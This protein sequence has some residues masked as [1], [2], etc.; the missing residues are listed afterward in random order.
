MPHEPPTKTHE[1]VATVPLTG[2]ITDAFQ[3]GPKSRIALLVYYRNTPEV[4]FLSQGAPVV[5]GRASPSNL[6]IPDKRLSR[7]HARFSLIDTRILVEDLGSTNGTWIHGRRITRAEIEVGDEVLLGHLTAEVHMLGSPND[8]PEAHAQRRA[9]REFVHQVPQRKDEEIVVGPAMQPIVEKARR[10]ATS[11][12]RVIL[13]GETGT[14]KEV[15]ARIIHEESGLGEKKRMVSVNCG[16]IPAPLVES[17]LFGHERGAFTGAVQHKGVFE[18]AD[19]GTIFLDEI[20]ELPPPAQVALLRV[21]ETG[22]FSRVGSTQELSTNVRV[23]AATHRDLKEMVSQG[24]FRSDLYYRLN[25]LM[26]AIP[27][28]RER[29]EEIEPL[30]QRF[31]RKA[32]EVNGRRVQGISQDALGLML[33]YSWPGNIRELKSAI[34]HAVVLAST[35]TIQ[36]GDLPPQVQ[37]PREGVKQSSRPPPG[38]GDSANDGTGPA[39]RPPGGIAELRER[40]LEYERRFFVE[41]LQAT[42]WNRKAAAQRLGMPLRTLSH[43][44]QVLGIKKSDD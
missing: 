29:K 16:A 41:V 8:S 36:V 23:I 17:T 24:S 20:G 4:Q 32:N 26:L 5:V 35:N 6:L 9:H 13:H 30:I 15:L 18:V 7:E 14:G 39:L 21:L 3:P 28:L 1:M 33:A 34:D 31:L 25:N 22:R 40:M 11:S 12:L 44:I 19:G 38:S 42:G 43:K 37:S 27:P 10:I 2:Q